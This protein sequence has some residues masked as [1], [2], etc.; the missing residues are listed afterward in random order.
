[1]SKLTA[2]LLIIIS[3]ISCLAQFAIKGKVLNQG[4]GKPIAN[5]SVFLN[6]ATIGTT[7]AADGTFTLKNV[8]PGKYDLVVSDIEFES[9]N[10]SVTITDKDLDLPPILVIAK[11]INLKEV[12][13][14]YHKDPNR[15]K[16][17]NLFKDEFLGNSQFAAECKI[18]NPAVLDLSYDDAKGILTA[19]SYDFLQ[20][21]N[22]ALGYKIKYLITNFSLENK[23]PAEKNIFYQG[24]V[25]FEE[26]HGKPGEE[27]RWERNREAVYE[28][29]PMHFL[30]ATIGGQLA[31]DGFRVQ[32]VAI[33]ENPE[34]PSDSLIN[35]HINYYRGLASLS[36]PQKDS[37][38]YWEKKSGLP[39]S[40][41]KLLPSPL[42]EKDII[43]PTIKSNQ[44]LL[45]ANNG[46]LFIAYSKNHR[47]H[48]D[49]H[50]QYLY[51]ANNKENTLVLFK[52]PEV[53]FYSNGVVSNPYSLMYYGVWGR[54]RVA[55]LLPI[56]YETSASAVQLN[57]NL[58]N[59][60]AKVD[61][62]QA[63][64]P[65]EKAYLQLDKPYYAAGDTIY[66]KAYVT[67]GEQHR[68]SN[69]SGVLHV[70]LINDNGQVNQTI[71][72]KL[73]SGISW[74][75][76]ALPDSL[77]SANYRIRAWT[78][79]MRNDP[80][81]F[82]ERVVPI[83]AINAPKQLPES[84]VKQTSAMKPVALAALH[85]DFQLLPEGGSL[86]EGVPCRIAFKA[87]GPDGLGIDVKGIVTD[88]DGRQ[89]ASFASTHL[90]MGY[91]ELTPAEGKSYSAKVTYASGFSDI[92]S[93]PKAEKSGITLSVNNDAIDKASV[94]ITANKT[95]FE[96][97]KGKDYALLVY[98]GDSVSMFSL[99]LDSQITR[100]DIL[101]R[102]LHTGVATIT[103]TSSQNEP[104][105]ERLLFIQ[106]YDRL[107][108]NISSDKTSYTA[109][110]KVHISLN[111][112]NHINLATTGHFSVSVV[113]ENKVP[114]NGSDEDNILTGLLLTSDL[115][116]PVEHPGYYFSDTTSDVRHNLD[117][118]MRTQGYRHF[119]WKQ[120]LEKTSPPY[121][122][123][124]ENGINVTGQVQDLFS[125][126]VKNGTVTLIS[127]NG[128]AIQ[129]TTTDDNG[130]FRFSNLTFNDT[131]RFVL[132]AVNARSRNNTKIILFSDAK[133]TP[134]ISPIAIA[135]KPMP[136]TAM[137][138]LAD[139]DKKQQ[140][141]LI[142]NGYLKGKI[143]KEVTVKAKKPDN[144]YRTFSLA[145]PGNADQ[146]MHS[147]EIEKVQGL[148][149]TSLNGRL[150][151]VT[152]IGDTA[153]L[154]TSVFNSI[155]KNM[156]KKMLIVLDGVEV[157]YLP[158]L[159][160][161]DVETVEVLKSANTSIYGMSG[162]GGVLIVTTKQQ[163]SLNTKDI[164]SHGLLPISVTG[165]YKAREFYSPK[166][167][168]LN[169]PHT[170]LRS[171][172]F[173]KPEL[174]TDKN[175]QASFEY[176]NA[177]GKGV[178]RIVI[179]GIDDNGN[180]GRQVFRYKVE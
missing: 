45:T 176:Y 11:T 79:L 27:R 68:L 39:K 130:N 67:L 89:V 72:L 64:H 16:Y 63:N 32:R 148:L 118:L 29:S 110:E 9:H 37:L 112:Q 47:F 140:L 4:D 153:Y 41:Q 173:W 12:A 25:L 69:L 53:F 10:Q 122:Y 38:S 46:G 66:F 177:D 161:T 166:Y 152:F 126:P 96:Q 55:E 18:L 150:R 54:N 80:T 85:P 17:L 105:C 160:A 35:A 103:L 82:F 87:V 14:K 30:R 172:V 151:G 120:V 65:L 139:N 93:L 31:K 1:M 88:N 19:S 62:F 157:N 116:G 114:E 136:F 73:D 119:T 15:E 58:Q 95:Y 57:D 20:I 165:F 106:N 159:Q 163:R 44:Y 117:L 77:Q 71:K 113:D 74:G 100:T 156:P 169:T 51:N 8:K 158:S 124:P 147:T 61:T 133:S 170:D 167:P 92:I 3:P 134:A 84:S 50:F 5:A 111:L 145:G 108:L 142:N 175:G 171:T 149:T 43:K 86:V 26:M 70:D 97:N 155:G 56:N 23:D 42:S 154:N 101:K 78:N 34:R 123:Q 131:T 76:F 75:D 138:I 125:K 104:L 36:R 129:S 48:I 178:Y 6:N 59:I 121:I 94:T 33:T 168:G 102:K 115:N 135:A 28:N 49:D 81:N 179:E 2:F 13:V 162:A 128:G 24:S 7:T 83:G 174:K 144:E 137:T 180:L 132:S 60:V 52:E 21:E 109:R 143:L 141:E 98:S 91:V 99:K 146:V 164:I 40:F 107:D 90:G 127:A 22:D